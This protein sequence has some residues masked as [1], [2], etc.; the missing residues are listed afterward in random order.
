V[1]A[2]SC[3]F[4]FGKRRTSRS[5]LTL[6]PS[7]P[8]TPGGGDRAKS[9]MLATCFPIDL[10]AA[11]GQLPLGRY[12]GCGAPISIQRRQV[13]R[14]ADRTSFSSA[15]CEVPAVPMDSHEQQ[16]AAVR[17]ARVQ[18]VTRHSPPT[19][20]PSRRVRVVIHLPG[21]LRCDNRSSG[22]PAGVGSLFPKN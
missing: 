7:D 17:F 18:P 21:S 16:A 20:I 5:D 22:L 8:G 6:E 13:A 19:R 4:Q 9:P 3:R 14:S 15:A 2:R 10:R 1:A 11:S 12:P